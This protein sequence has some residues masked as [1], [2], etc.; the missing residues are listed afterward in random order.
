[1]HAATM[2]G[3]ASGSR[4]LDRLRIIITFLQIIVAVATS[5]TAVQLLWFLVPSS[6]VRFRL[7]FQFYFGSARA[8]RRVQNRSGLNTKSI[9]FV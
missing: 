1:M 9:Q 8:Y 7:L 5:F 3:P 6:S 2:L 4:G